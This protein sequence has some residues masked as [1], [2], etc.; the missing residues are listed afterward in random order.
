VYIVSILYMR[1]RPA[2]VELILAIHNSSAHFFRTKDEFVKNLRILEI[3][4]I[5]ALLF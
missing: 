5:F 1:F 2:K 3:V 4:P